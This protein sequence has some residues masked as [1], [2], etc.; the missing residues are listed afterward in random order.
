MGKKLAAELGMEFLDSDHVI[1]HQERR[2]VAEIFAQEGEEYFRKKEREF[3]EKGHPGEGCVVACGGGLITREGILEQLQ[4]KGV[5]VCLWA[6]PETILKRTEGNQN[7]PLLR[8]PDPAGRIRQLLAEREPIYRK[9]G[10]LVTTDQRSMT[11]IVQ[12]IRRVFLEEVRWRENAG[13][14]GREE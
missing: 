4:Q 9:A 8:H 3:V 10:T 6:T 5:V 2:T 7:R 12:H 11:D 14:Q 13:R 1:E